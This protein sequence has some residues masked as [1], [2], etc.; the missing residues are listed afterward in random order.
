MDLVGGSLGS[1][2]IL[3]CSGCTM[4]GRI[5][6]SVEGSFGRYV[7]ERICVG[8]GNAEIS[9]TG[10]KKKK[11]GVYFIYSSLAV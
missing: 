4:Q 11:R 5:Y 3:D 8:Q 6:R 1:N 10:S 2:Q 9:R 7:K